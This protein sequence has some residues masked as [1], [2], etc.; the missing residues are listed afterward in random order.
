[1]SQAGEIPHTLATLAYQNLLLKQ[2]VKFAYIETLMTLAV[3]AECHHQESSYHPQRMSNYS[4]II[5][6]H[7]GL[8]TEEQEFIYYA[9]LMHDIGKIGIP[10]S[11]LHKQ[12][13]LTAEERVI[14]RKHAQMGADILSKSDAPL[15]RMSATIALTHHEKFDGSGYPNQLKG[16]E[17]PIAGRIA[18]LAD[19]F[20]ALG[21]KRSYKEAWDLKKIFIW[22]EEHT[23]SHFDPEVVSAFEKGKHEVI[24]IYHHYQDGFEPYKQR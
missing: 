1:M 7:L 18:A 9:S 22:I 4:R 3:A 2:E 17:I 24:E 5:A 21:S 8:S 13:E 16:E 10:D 20:D 14:M 12:G 15:M 19:V 11:I 23:G 6:A